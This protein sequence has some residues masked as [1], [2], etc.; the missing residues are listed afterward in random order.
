MQ[1]KFYTFNKRKNS[2]KL[3]DSTGKTLE[4]QIKSPSSVI[5]PVIEL[6]ATNTPYNYNYAYCPEYS[7]Y[8]YVKDW[9][10][11]KG[12]WIGSLTVDP[13]ASFRSNIL[14]YSAFIERAKDHFDNMINDNLLSQKQEITIATTHKFLDIFSE[15]GRF[16]VN[17]NG[18]NTTVTGTTTFALTRSGMRGFVAGLYDSSSWSDIFA[19]GF[20]KGVFNPL[21]YVNWIKWIPLSGDALEPV[22]GQAQDLKIGF[23]TVQDPGS[24]SIDGGH[25]L[26]AR[27]VTSWGITKAYAIQN[28]NDTA[29][30]FNDWRD[31]NGNYTKYHMY[32]PAYGNYEIAPEI[33]NLYEKI[34][35]YYDIDL[36]TCSCNIR[37]Y[38]AHTNNSN[39]IGVHITDLHG[40]IGADL[41]ASNVSINSFDSLSS[42][43]SSAGKALSGDII[44]AVGGGIE[45]VKNAITPQQT[46]K[47]N[48]SAVYTLMKY[49]DIEVT[50][51]AY[52]SAEYPINHMGRPVCK[53]M[54]LSQ[55][56][57]YVKC[58]NA[59]IYLPATSGEIE[60]VNNT[61]NT[62]VYIE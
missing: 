49:N 45:A 38:G 43:L 41:L 61:L 58:G 17:V 35:V 59:S 23:W 14:N 46:T 2:T 18:A 51:Y 6:S 37:L 62:G 32:I 5:E 29:T 24:G 10:F 47:G 20:M 22:L 12:L 33:Y 52:G 25:N 50:K 55:F 27:A 9:T 13:L 30:K 11:D 1:F 4:V 42:A 7:R 60:T 54:K 48:N 15:D 8:Y 53:L 57:G 44:G 39:D 36:L 40:I 21:D 26:Q 16:L 34:N 19:D 31:N 56:T 3:P 28:I